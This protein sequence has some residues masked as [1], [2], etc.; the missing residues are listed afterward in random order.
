[1]DK[2]FLII[3][4]EY[5]VNVKKKSFLIMTLLAPFLMVLFLA[6]VVYIG[7]ANNTEKKIAVIDESGLF[8]NKLKNTQDL[9]FHFFNPKESMNLKDSV[10]NTETINLLIEIPYAKDSLFS[11]LDHEISLIVKNDVDIHTKEYLTKT[12]RDVLEEKRLEVLGISPDHLAQ[13][14]SKVDFNVLS[15]SSNQ[16]GDASL[17][18]LSLAS[19]L[20]Y[21]V[22]MFI[23]I[24][25]VRVMRSVIEEKNSR[26]VEVII[27]S[28]KPM[29]L[30]IG[31]IVGTALVALTQFVIWIALTLFLMTI[32]QTFTM[33]D[34]ESIQTFQQG[35]DKIPNPDNLNQTIEVLFNLNYPFIIATFLLF[36]TLGYLFFSSFFAAI[37]SAVDNETETQQFTFLAIAPL[38]IGGYGSFTSLMTNPEGNILAALSIFP[39]TSPVAMVIRS[40]YEVPVWQW[41]LAI[42]LLVGATVGMIYIAAKIYRTGILMYGKKASFKEIYKWLKY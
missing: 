25:G 12:F 18:K 9:S 26:V 4:R 23:M 20:A 22:F 2:V 8:Q 42:V 24:Y 3:K 40:P 15:L 33:N 39:M 38:M 6:V 11:N 28:V 31:K 29:Q 1:M 37:G 35:M 19:G 41:I 16:R 14:K 32:Y 7:Q 36:F 27:S 30:M 5:L 13:S 34:I 10:F 21:I 17:I